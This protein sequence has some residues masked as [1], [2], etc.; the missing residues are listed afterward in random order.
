M[1]NRLVLICFLLLS[2]GGEAKNADKAEEFKD[3][4][5]MSVQSCEYSAVF[6]SLPLAIKMAQGQCPEEQ[7]YSF[8]GP[9]N[10]FITSCWWC[11]ESGQ[12]V[13]F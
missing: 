1:M 3:D 11:S 9:C 8:S 12:E 13:S 2:L 10:R 6:S 5:G 4:T 7:F